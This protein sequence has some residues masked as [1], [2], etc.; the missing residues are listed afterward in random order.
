M[1]A[2]RGVFIPSFSF[3]GEQA[4]AF[5]A[6]LGTTISPYLLFWQPGQEVEELGLRHHQRLGAKPQA[7]K[8]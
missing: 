6:V 8:P 5:V 3:G 4:M 7:A 1:E 2:A